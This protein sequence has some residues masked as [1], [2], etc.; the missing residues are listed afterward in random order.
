MLDVAP[1]VAALEARLADDVALHR[2]PAKFGFLID[3]G[4]ALP[5]GDV[6]A[7]V[8]FEAFASA[9]G[10]RFAIALA[11]DGDVAAPMRGAGS[12]RRRRGVARAFLQL[13]GNSANPL[14]RMI[15]LV[16]Q[17][18]AAAVLAAAGLAALAPPAPLRRRRAA[19]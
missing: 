2:L 9:D 12:A 19:L 18:G 14:T 1:I 16:A 7:D 8:R 5:L 13:A 3:G 4:G 15:G 10:P 17:R 11:G 6:E